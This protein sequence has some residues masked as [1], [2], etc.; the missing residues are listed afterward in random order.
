MYQTNNA[1]SI[2]DRW[3]RTE[4]PREYRFKTFWKVCFKVLLNK[5]DIFN[6]TEKIQIH[7]ISINHCA[8]GIDNMCLWV[9][10]ATTM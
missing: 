10:T 6:E 9:Q 8:A 4:D 2:I 7:V 3:N 5:S 1:R